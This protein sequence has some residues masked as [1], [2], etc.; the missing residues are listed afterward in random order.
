[1]NEDKHGRHRRTDRDPRRRPGDGF[2]VR[3]ADRFARLVTGALADLPPGLRPFVDQV[4]L[5]IVDVPPN[6]PESGDQP[7]V[8]AHSDDPLT[9]GCEIRLYRRPIELR[10]RSRTDL[11]EL[12]RELVVEHV[13]AHFDLDD[14]RLDEL[15][16]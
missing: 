16:W 12:V 13:A 14:D 9:G 10:A 15:G 4:R 2:R 8:A 5:V 6:A 11:A 3:G 1:V 7:I